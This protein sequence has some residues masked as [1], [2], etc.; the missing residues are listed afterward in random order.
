MSRYNFRETEAK[1]QKIWAERSC[2]R[3]SDDPAREKYYV[4]EMFPY[5]SG[6][7]HIGHARNYAIGDVLARYKKANGFNVLHPMGWDAFGLPAENAAIQNNVHPADWTYENIRVMRGQ[8][9]LLGLSYDWDR[10]FA[11]CDPD[12]YRHE[13][14]MFLDFV[15]SGLAYR[16]ESWV[17]WDP[18][19]NTVLANEQ[20]IDGKGWRTGAT[21]ERRKL[22][23]WFLKIT[24]YADELQEALRG[25]DRWPDR[26]RLMQ[27][28]WI[29]RSVGAQVLFALD[30]RDEPLEVFST[31]P[32]TL[33]GASFLAIS[34]DHP[35]A[36]ELAAGNDALAEFV[37]ECRRMGTSEEVIE[38]AEKR[39]L[40]TGL[41]A[42]HPFMPDVS[43]PVHVANFV[44]MEYGSGAVF[45]CPAH[46]QR[47][48]DFARKYDLPVTSVLWP[49]DTT[50]VTD[51]EAANWDDTLRARFDAD[52]VQEVDGR[53]RLMHVGR[54]A[55]TDTGRAN[56]SYD[57]GS[58][59]DG[60]ALSVDEAKDVVV[61]ALEQQGQ[62]EAAIRYRLRDWG[63]SRQR[64]WGCPIPV[65][66]RVDDGA[67]VPVPDSDLPVE[68]PKDID[69]TKP[70]NPLEN[71]PTWKHTICPATGKPAIRETDTFDTF[72]ESSWY[73]LRFCSPHSAEAFNPQAADYWMPVDQYIGGIEHAVLHLLY[74]RFFTRALNQSGHRVA[75]EPFAGLMTQGMVVHE[76]YR[77]A[78][79]NWL[80]P[81]EVTTMDGAL[82]TLKDGGPVTKGRLEKMSK[83]KKNVVGLETVVDGFGADTGR[84]VLLSDSPPERD[85]EW[86][87]AG[88]EG[89]WR[90][91]NR[92]W[93]LISEPVVPLAPI[94]TAAPNNLSQEAGALRREV[95][96]TI[97]AVGHDF[98]NFRI[99][100][101][102][103]RLR[104]LTN[105]IA[106]I[107]GKGD[108][109]AWALREALE[110]LSLM[111]SPVMPHFAEEAW[112]AL[113][114]QELATET[115]WPIADPALA[116]DEQI[117][118]GVQVNGKLRG[119]VT[120][121]KDADKTA[122]EGA[123]LAEPN[124]MRA[125]DGKTVRKVIVV[126]NRIVNVVAA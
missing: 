53:G 64:Y 88:L 101:A 37:E 119:T 56:Y 99:N 125:L 126:P 58:L 92:L 40:D 31:R 94:G 74:S 35:L 46:D 34:P 77:D 6:R 113:G 14:K 87:D 78:D 20:V 79:G 75:P 91:V 82:V 57:L 102:I 19:D 121:P 32:D 22:T 28:N 61:K 33:F 73:F 96:K 18:V 83:S 8:L 100:R 36:E 59:T 9:Q 11:T 7:L 71:H 39:G 63:V 23:Q 55:Y 68:L 15:R 50:M 25:L 60:K 107:T 5:P 112:S 21:V 2:D 29:G 45:G 111:I 62:G 109:E 51:R 106:G 76:T 4:L 41:R 80:F 69:L 47:D 66:Y 44:L 114:H 89:A 104:E 122:A 13:Q 81:E 17:N 24:E 123:A 16:K 105:A 95:H 118:M 120:L 72:F 52:P 42:R 115:A 116:V 49:T 12:Y 93:R 90:Y 108:G 84:L 3:T 86:S 38:T 124:V 97:A 70:G 54:T 27:E 1:W 103:A 26:V 98:E 110:A 10:E 48:L 65:M 85:L 30:G 67:M 43:L 117:T